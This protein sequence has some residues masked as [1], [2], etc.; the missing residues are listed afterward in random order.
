M[1]IGEDWKR[2]RLARSGVEL[3]QTP[4]Q[5]EAEGYHLISSAS[6]RIYQ[7]AN[8][9]EGTI[10]ILGR[11]LRN[12]DT[13][14]NGIRWLYNHNIMESKDLSRDDFVGA[15]QTLFDWCK[16]EELFCFLEVTN[17]GPKTS[18]FY[19]HARAK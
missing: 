15:V 8:D 3:P 12:E 11:R 10:R 13:A 7:A 6:V 2:I 18:A 5:I 14:R 17:P 16:K 1:S 19:L 4:R 9:D